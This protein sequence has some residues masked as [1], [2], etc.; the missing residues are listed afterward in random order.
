[1]SHPPLSRACIVLGLAIFFAAAGAGRAATYY[2]DGSRASASD[3]NPGT[4]EAPWKTIRRAT[5]AAEPGDIVIVRAGTYREWIYFERGGNTTAGPIVLSAAPGENVVI[6]GKG[7]EDSSNGVFL[8]K[9]HVRIVGLE[10]ANW[11]SNAMWIEGASHFEI[12]DCEVHHVPYGIGVAMGSHDFVF[13]RVVAH[14]FDLYGFDVSPNGAP[15]FNGTFNDCVAHTGRDRQQNVDGFAL[16]HGDQHGF[17]FNRCTAYNVFDG[18]DISSR[19]TTLSRCLAYDCWNG[20]YK[21][22]QDNVILVNCIGY[23]CAGA[24]VELDWDGKPRTTTLIN[25]TFANAGAY[26][27]WVENKNDRLRM[28]NCILAGGDNIGLAFEQM[29]VKNYQGDYNIFHNNNPHRAVAVAYEDEFTLDQV[30]SGAWTAYS[31][32]DAH[33]LVCRSMEEL[34]IDPVK[35]DFRLRPGSPAVDRG[36]KNGAPDSD[37]EGNPRPSGKGFDIGAFEYLKKPD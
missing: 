33:S 12:K 26:T 30:R 9:S 27:I 7:V 1:M 24:I 16:G 21:L 2:V 35:L 13:N 3:S 15:C 10:V 29:G 6:D 37:H 31:G 20:A 28:Y 4:P 32:Q 22:W 19:D 14:H 34:F 11:P 8:D 5:D 23:S 17:R 25:C 18:F 36:T